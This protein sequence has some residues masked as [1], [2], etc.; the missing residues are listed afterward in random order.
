MGKKS[1]K[2]SQTSTSAP[3]SWAVPILEGAS[4]SILDTV[5]GNQGNLSSLSSSLNNLLPQI[6]RMAMDTSTLN[7]GLG[8]AN[9]VLGGK[10]LNANPYVDQMAQQAGQNAGNFVNSSFSMAGRTGGGNNIERT[11][12]GVAN[13][14]NAI[15]FQNY[16]NERGLQSQAASMLPGYQAS[17]TAGL[18]PLLG[19]YQTAA[20]I[21]YSGIQ[22][23]GQIGGLLGGYGSTTSTG[24]QPGGWG[25][26]LLGGLSNMFSF[27]PIKL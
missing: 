13:A 19:A 6:G 15:R 10:Y 9:D 14:E 8:Y 4:N 7:G 18:A 25:T 21:P 5:K 16:Q 3:P 17:R 26:A 23:L 1:T 27:S 24:R 20:D 12:E 11:A 22:N 2:S